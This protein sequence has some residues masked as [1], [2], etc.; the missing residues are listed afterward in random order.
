MDG[1]T[2]THGEKNRGQDGSWIFVLSQRKDG[3]ALFI[4]GYDQL[5]KCVQ[6][7]L[8]RD[9]DVRTAVLEYGQFSSVFQ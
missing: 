7:E 2:V 6:G 8:L 1:A 9:S 5:E 3:L 4:F